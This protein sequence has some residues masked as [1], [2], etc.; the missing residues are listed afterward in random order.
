MVMG[1]NF[2]DPERQRRGMFIELDHPHLAISGGA[3]Y[4]LGLFQHHI[5]GSNYGRIQRRTA[6]NGE[7]AESVVSMKFCGEFTFPILILL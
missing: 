4:L 6:E 1:I 2:I 3:T 7:E 5:D